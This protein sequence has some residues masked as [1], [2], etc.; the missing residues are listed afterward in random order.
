MNRVTRVT[1]NSFKV[2]HF[3]GLFAARKP[4]FPRQI[5]LLVLCHQLPRALARYAELGA[6]GAQGAVFHA[7]HLICS[8]RPNVRWVFFV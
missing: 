3:A 7:L 6:H 8:A 2:A 1:F 4:A 5:G